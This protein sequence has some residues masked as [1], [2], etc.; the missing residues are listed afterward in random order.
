MID[1][2]LFKK[3]EGRLYRYYKSIKLIDRL[4]H[5]CMVLEKA[6]DQLRQ[7]L[8]ST[9]IDIEADINMGIS[10]DE[11]VQTS[12]NGTSYVEQETMKQIEK[13]EMEWKNTRKQILKVHAKIR[14]IKKENA[15]MEYIVGLLDTQYKLIAEMKY[16]DE[17][18]LEK[19]GLKL[20]MDKST[21]SRMRVKIVEEISKVLNA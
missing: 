15:D 19:I 21:V 16:K 6:K 20:N 9:N 13:L 7:D 5:R 8:R 3:T 18:S 12:P 10:Y 4:E 11:R 2:E 17:S 14:E 1:K